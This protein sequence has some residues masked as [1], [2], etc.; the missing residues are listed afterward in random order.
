MLALF[1]YWY[2]KNDLPIWYNPQECMVIVNVDG[3]YEV[4]DP[5]TKQW[6]HIKRKHKT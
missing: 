6:K 5:T 4:T 1:D 3:N 2:T